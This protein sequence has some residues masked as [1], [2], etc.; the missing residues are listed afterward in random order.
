L[1]GVEM[2]NSKTKSIIL[3]FIICIIFLGFYLY[4]PTEETT[5]SKPKA[6]IEIKEIISGEIIIHKGE[7]LHFSALNSSDEDGKI[8]SYYWDFDDG[9][10][11]SSG[12][13]KHQYGSPGVY[14]VTLTVIDNDGKTNLTSIQITVINNDPIAQIGIN[15]HPAPEL[16]EIPVYYTIQFNSTGSY[17]LDGE[18]VIWSWDFGDGNISTEQN[19]KYTY[20]TVGFYTV[21][22]TVYDDNGALATNTMDLEII[23]RTYHVEW[24]LEEIELVIEPNGY[25]LEGESTELLDQVEQDYIS[26]IDI[27]LNWTDRQPFLDDNV[28]EGEDVFELN[29]LTPENISEIKNSSAGKIELMF[30]YISLVTSREYNAKTASEAITYAYSEAGFKGEGSGEWY[31]NISAIECKGGSWS[32][33]RFDFDI[34]NIWSLRMII[35]YYDFEITDIT[36]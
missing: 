28:T 25:T 12:N 4:S 11:S 1:I 3:I 15:N 13:P 19:P 32:N 6:K 17:D 18:I 26:K 31:F 16:G 10:S 21:E 2:K 22:L 27:I 7:T 30:Q 8:E 23:L 33:D 35:Y 36:N 24:T 14:Y 9:N 29:I 5:H 34:G 20:D